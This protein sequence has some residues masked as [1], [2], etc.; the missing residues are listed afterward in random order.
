MARDGCVWI[1]ARGMVDNDEAAD[2]ATLI[3]KNNKN[4]NQPQWML[5]LC[6][7]HLCIKIM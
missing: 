2:G 3:F 7:V 4:L 5:I 1:S 6:F